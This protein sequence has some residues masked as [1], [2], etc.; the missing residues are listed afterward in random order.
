MELLETCGFK[1]R[2]DRNTG[3]QID[4]TVNLGSRREVADA[5]VDFDRGEPAGSAP[6]E[7]P[8]SPEPP[9]SKPRSSGPAKPDE[10]IYRYKDAAGS[11]V[12]HVHRIDAPGRKKDIWQSYPNGK[13]KGKLPLYGLPNLLKDPSKPTLIVEGEKAVDGALGIAVFAAWNVHVQ[14][15]G[16]G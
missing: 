8:G 4:T 6:P 12:L 3:T 11:E 13:S 16:S 5:P 14:R 9:D 1:D 2:D 10:V 15:H 7:P